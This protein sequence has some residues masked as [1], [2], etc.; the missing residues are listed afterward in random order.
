MLRGRPVRAA[1]EAHGHSIGRR[2]F[3]L[4]ERERLV[5]QPDHVGLCSIPRW[6]FAGFDRLLIK[7]DRPLPRVRPDA[8]N[9]GVALAAILHKDQWTGTRMVRELISPCSRIFFAEVITERPSGRW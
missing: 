8:L 5:D 3:H 1:R 4:F 9:D 2:R 6:C 7:P